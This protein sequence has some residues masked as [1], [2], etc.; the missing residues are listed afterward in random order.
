M[1]KKINIGIVGLGRISHNHID[2]IQKNNKF[3]NL[4]GLCDS[5]KNILKKF[6]KFK[7]P[8][9]V[10]LKELINIDDI[11]IVS[12]CTPSGIH[13]EQAVLALN[14]G[15]N[16]I[17]EKPM[18]TNLFDANKMLK[19]AKKNKKKLFVVKQNRFNPTLVYL[20]KLLEEKKLGKIYMFNSNVFW[21]RSQSYYNSAKWRGKKDLDGGALMNQASHYI[22]MID[23]FFGPIKKLSAYCLTLQRKIEMEDSTVVNFI[24]KNNIMGSISVTMLSY[25]KNFEGSLTIISEMGNIKIGGLAL[26]EIQDINLKDKKIE[27]DLKKLSYN[28]KNIYGN[29]HIKYYSNVASTLIKNTKPSTDGYEGYKSLKLIISAYES[30]KNGNNI[31]IS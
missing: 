31:N 23:W 29:G 11:D 16:V 24:S 18:A 5:N 17:T 4:V 14:N 30:A 12:L 9:F 27:K 22:D 1:N 25:E 13:S 15:I 3:F 7:L 10:N 19:A 28:I 8:L 26:N 20:K 21:H 6:K 2:A